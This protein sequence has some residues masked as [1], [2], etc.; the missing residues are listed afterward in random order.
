MVFA[1]VRTNILPKTVDS[2]I[3]LKS[4]RNRLISELIG[5][6]SVSSGFWRP[7]LLPWFNL[8]TDHFKIDIT[9]TLVKNSNYC[10]T[11]SVT[12]A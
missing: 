6:G 9:A 1:L 2:T 5:I 10:D 4:G 12:H 3:L 7:Q 8:S 11:G